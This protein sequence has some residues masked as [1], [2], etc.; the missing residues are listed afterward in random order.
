VAAQERRERTLREFLENTTHDV[1]IPL[2]VMQG[3]L[4]A[5]FERAQQSGPERES[6]AGAVREAHYMA[7]LI[8]NLA[9]AAKLDAGEPLLQKLPVNL[10]DVLQRAVSRHVP[11]ARRSEVAL[12]VAV[13]PDGVICLGDVTLIE[14]ALSNVIYN[15]VRYNRPGGHVAAILERRG[16]RFA[17]RIVY[18]GPGIPEE[19]R[20]RLAERY[21]RGQEARGR[22]Q[23]SGL[24]LHIASR[25]ATLHGWQLALTAPDGGGLQVE[26]TGST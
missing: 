16:Q 24:G 19:E 4:A 20:A 15:A 17:V 18:D 3:H 21:F 9:A 7:S 2:T 6:L 5:A 26:L 23:G 1:M 8:H 10:S 25:V 12:E 11:F 14:Q 13:P 22:S